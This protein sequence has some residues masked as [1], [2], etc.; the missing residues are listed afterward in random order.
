MKQS[1][2]GLEQSQASKHSFLVLDLQY[3]FQTK[4]KKWGKGEFWGVGSDYDPDWVLTERQKKLRDNLIELCRTK[5][6]PHAADYD[7]NYTFPRESLNALAELD[8]LALTVPKELGGLGESHICISMV[9]E[10]LA[11]YGC[12]STA[13]VYNMHVVA[14]SMLVC[15][16]HDSPYIQDLLRRINKEKLIGT[17]AFSDPGTGSH[18]WFPL[19][20]KCKYVDENT[21]QLFRYCSWAT[22]CG[23]ADW[24]AI[25]SISPDFEGDYS[26]LT[27]FLVY[28]DEIRTNTD[29]W[30]AL[31]MHGN[32]SGPIIVEGKFPKKRILGIPGD[33]KENNDECAPLAFLANSAIWNGI[34]LACIDVAKKHVTRKAHADVGM[35]VCDYPTIQDYFGECMCDTNA[36]RGLTHLG[37]LALDENTIS[38]SNC[39]SKNKYRFGRDKSA[40]WLIQAKLVSAKN[41]WKVSDKMLQACG[42][43]G[44]RTDLGLERL[45]RDG[46]AGWVM[47]LSNEVVRQFVGKTLLE[48]LE[49]V[50]FWQQKVN[51]RVLHQEVQKMSIDERKKLANELLED[52][53]AEEAGREAKH[54]FQDSDFDN[55]F[56]T[57]PPAAL[58]KVFKTEDGV[59]H[60]PALK[61]DTWVL[62]TL[63]SRTQ[64]N[65]KM[66]AFEFSLPKPT[67]HTG[68]FTGQ[69][70]RVRVNFKGKEQERYFSPVSRPD[71]FGRIELVLRFE[72]H[73]QMS[74]H[75]QALRPGDQVEF[76]GPCGGFEYEANQLDEVTL[77]ASGGGI[78]P[79]MQLIRAVMHNPDDRTKIKLLYSSENYDEILFR[80][81]LDRY[82]AKDSRLHI[83]HTLGESPEDWDGEEGFI[84]T[85]MIDKHVTK[86]N[87]LRQKIIMCGGPTMVLSCLYSLRSLGF[88]SD[89]IFIYGQFGTE[90]VRKVYGRN[91]QLSCHRCDSVL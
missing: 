30:K 24:Y 16:C 85:Q 71:D 26:R 72:T 32:M 62:F 84:D 13:M 91:V 22:S 43:S 36:S 23:H 14:V 90:H 7:K 20:S 42:G 25:Q 6:R 12:P 31:G 46:K 68:C 81:E 65:D 58:S 66:A 69:Y 3:K 79:G 45:F 50:D 39:E 9:F 83:V 41:V 76:Q 15:D 17:I 60:E 27:N 35:R 67:D 88:P 59:A 49:A 55:P 61:P 8:L 64:L 21:V 11:R 63:K 37:A 57:C 1:Q 70:V 80:D 28:K 56:N 54:P 4:M 33:A 52:V 18:F 34:S 73:G 29:D 2:A 47:A 53:R 74:Q 77:L 40:H 5:I 89:A 87:D 78:T 51:E 48:N 75:F 44:Y 82:A 10:T 86:P 38:S 19:S